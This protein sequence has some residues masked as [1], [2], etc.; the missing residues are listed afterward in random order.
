MSESLPS[1]LP[2]VPLQVG[3]LPWAWSS[4]PNDSLVV[5]LPRGRSPVLPVSP[6]EAVPHALLCGLVGMLPLTIFLRVSSLP[7]LILLAVL[8]VSHIL[9]LELSGYSKALG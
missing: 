9:V 4:S 1:F 6:C 2:S 3:C 7:K 8:S 5:L